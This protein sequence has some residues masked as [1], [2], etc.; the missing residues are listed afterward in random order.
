[1]QHVSFHDFIEEVNK[2]PGLPANHSV[3]PKMKEEP[4]KHHS[5]ERLKFT[6]RGRWK[7]NMMYMLQNKSDKSGL[8]VGEKAHI[9][10]LVNIC[11]ESQV[12]DS[13]ISSEE[14]I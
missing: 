8:L 3:A 4:Y 1:M 13:Q 5:L 10:W 7:A 12:G 6:P 14:L 2:Q 11:P 9:I